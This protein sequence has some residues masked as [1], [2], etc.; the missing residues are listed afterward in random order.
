MGIIYKARDKSLDEVIAL[1][2]LNDYLCS[3]DA[4]VERFKREARAAKR[5]SHPSI[6]RIHDMYEVGDRKFLSMEYIEGTDL[7]TMMKNKVKFT[8]KQVLFYLLKICD[9]LEYAHNMGVVHRD[10]KPANIMITKENTIKITDF[11]IAK[12][13][14][15]SDTNKLQT[16][17]LGTP[18]YMAPEQIIG[19]RVDERTDIYS[20]G[21]TLYELIKGTPPFM[22]GN[23]EYHHVHSE[24]EPLPKSDTSKLQRII[25]KCIQK[26]L[27]ERFQS[28]KEIFVT[29]RKP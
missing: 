4:A 8:E 14:H 13:L 27:K 2:V 24:P 11:G 5:L 1:K 12:V 7:R 9:A 28:V 26:N 10:I 25:M 15:A 23:V 18:L 20:L 6:V 19:E 3:D 16:A 21:I 29:A 22:K 17:I